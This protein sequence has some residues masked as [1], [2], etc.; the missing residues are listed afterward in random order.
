MSQENTPASSSTDDSVCRICGKQPFCNHLGVIRYEV[1]VDDPRFGK[2]FRCPYNDVAYD[3]DRQEKLRRLSHLEAF[4]ER[5]FE[6]FHVDLPMLTPE[7][8]QS[9]RMAYNMAQ[10]FAR[11]PR[12][13]MLLEGTYGCGKTHLAAAVGNARLAHGDVVIFVT[14]P[15]LL[16]HL[17][18]T[19]GPTSETSYDETFDRIRNASLLIL[20]DL[21][22]ENPSAWAQEKLFQ[23][24]NHRYSHELPTV[25][26]TNADIDRIDARIRSR[27]LH[28]ELTRRIK[29]TAPDFRS[30]VENSRL[31]LI[32]NLNLYD[33]M[34]FDT[35]S[36][37]RTLMPAERENLERGLALAQDYARQPE[38]WLLLMGE[39]G[40]GKTHLAAA[41]ANA[42]Q[43]QGGKVMF[44][45]V[46]DLLD[47]L[48]VTFD[49]SASISFDERFQAVRRTD[50]LVLDDLGTEN[51]SGW[52]REKLFQIMDHRYVARLPTVITTARSID[53]LDERVRS[54]VLDERRC[55]IFALTLASYA[56][57]RK[58]G[59]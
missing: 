4:A 10:D 8:Q 19:Y 30:A 54:R 26:T 39:Y 9:L 41:I 14:V 6:T 59:R 12:G 2:L 5:T 24:L 11:S 1:P 33:D 47:Y 53:T 28:A 56:E 23:L 38:G 51:T 49:P 18:G 55:R 22:V 34:T 46:P 52:A 37:D 3:S 50:F 25:I 44:V 20:D 7:D 57:R 13:W 17:R 40:T 21:G 16:D 58:R 43:H 15:D 29:I 32:S 31:Q 35:F 36:I 45:T 27:I 42:I 48:R